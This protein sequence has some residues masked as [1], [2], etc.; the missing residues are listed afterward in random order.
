MRRTKP[1]LIYKKTKNLRVIQLLLAIRNWTAQS[2]IW[3]L[4]SMMRQR[5]L[6]RLESKVVRAATA[7]LCQK[8]K[9]AAGK[10][11]SA[12]FRNR[13]VRTSRIQTPNNIELFWSYAKRPSRLFGASLRCLTDVMRSSGQV[14]KA[15]GQ[16]ACVEL[17]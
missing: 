11:V 8:R 14:K 15:S 9:L 10:H 7:V 5:S 4:K 16:G 12:T 13:P 1:Y 2:V 6:N 3:A 17:K